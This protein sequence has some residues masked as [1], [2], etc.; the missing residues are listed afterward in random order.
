MRDYGR[1]PKELLALIFFILV[2]STASAE[3][4]TLWGVLKDA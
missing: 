4:A 2:A 1:L 3:E